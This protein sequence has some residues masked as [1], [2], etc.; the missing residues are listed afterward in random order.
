MCVCV[1]EKDNMEKSTDTFLSR[2]SVIR[3]NYYY[4]QKAVLP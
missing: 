1:C 4:T 2:N 3:M